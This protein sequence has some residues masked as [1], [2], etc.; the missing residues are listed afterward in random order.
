MLFLAGPLALAGV[1]VTWAYLR[2]PRPFTRRAYLVVLFLILVANVVLGVTGGWRY[3]LTKC[4]PCDS[5]VSWP[6][7]VL[8]ASVFIVF[9]PLMKRPSSTS[10]DRR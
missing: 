1:A 9:A 6:K 3:A 10:V 2:R 7:S 4:E 5:L 8:V